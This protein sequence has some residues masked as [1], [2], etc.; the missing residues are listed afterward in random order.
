MVLTT[1]TITTTI[2]FVLTRARIM[3]S[4]CCDVING[5]SKELKSNC[6]DTH[7]THRICLSHEQYQLLHATDGV[8]YFAVVV[9]WLLLSDD[10][11]ELQLH[12]TDT[13]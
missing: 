2:I 11:E 6:I 10:D 4:S 3:I 5:R 13:A 12:I 9:E 8:Q 7:I 1:S